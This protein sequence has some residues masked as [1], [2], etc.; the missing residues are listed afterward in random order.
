M[1]ANNHEALLMVSYL[2][3]S[4]IILFLA[5]FCSF[6]AWAIGHNYLNLPEKFNFVTPC[7]FRTVEEIEAWMRGEGGEVETAAAV[8]KQ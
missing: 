4:N 1:V 3:M 5:F 6:M 8:G 2:L 7:T